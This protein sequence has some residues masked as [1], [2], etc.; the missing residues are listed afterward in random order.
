MDIEKLK[1]P[2]GEFV[3]PKDFGDGS[4]SKWISE[5]EVL[6]FH[7]KR[8]LANLTEDQLGTAYRPDGWTIKQLVH[9]IGDS[10][11]NAYSRLKF[12]LTEDTPTIKPYQQEAWV[13]TPDGDLDISIPLNLITA[14]HTKWVHIYKNITQSQW[15]AKFFHPDEKEPQG[16]DY[17]CAKYAWH[18]KHHLAHITELARRESW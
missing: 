17:W 15:Q 16:I 14:I 5:I 13:N 1:Y 6:P 18:G 7:L 3:V 2:I 9:H 4:K 12:A 10:H 11:L 8:A